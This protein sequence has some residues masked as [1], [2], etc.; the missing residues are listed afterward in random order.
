MRYFTNLE[1]LPDEV[2]LGSSVSRR[3]WTATAYVAFCLGIFARQLIPYPR[4]VVESANLR[5]SCLLA[6]FIIGLAL[7]P[8]VI[9]W[10]NVR[11]RKPSVEHVVTAFSF[12]FFVDLASSGV[13]AVA[14][15]TH[16]LNG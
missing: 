3:R 2:D 12:G 5:W 16:I 15:V 13:A 14:R 4:V 1:F 9:R 11:R 8:P 10:L 6:S 7:F